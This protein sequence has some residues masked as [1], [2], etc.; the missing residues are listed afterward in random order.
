MFKRDQLILFAMAVLTLLVLGWAVWQDVQPEYLGYQRSFKRLVADKLGPEKAANVR[1]GV[2]QVWI[3]SANR[4]DRCMTCHLGVSWTGLDDV[5]E[6]FRSHPV[7]PLKNHPI[8]KFGCTFCH[9]GQGSATKRVDAHGWIKHWK[10]PLLDT[11][12]SED[13]QVKEP[14]AFLQMKCNTCHRYDRETP[15][16][17]YIN[18][19]KKLVNEKGCRACHTINERGGTIGPDLT[20]AGD[21]APE[22]YDYTR[23]TT[24]PSV[25][26]WQVAHMQDPKAYSPDT[27][28]PDFGLDSQASQAMAMLL[29]SWK[30]TELPAEFMHGAKIRDLPTP[31]E[32]ERE[33]V[34][35]EGEGKFFV[36]KTCFICHDVSSLGIVSATKIGPDLAIAEDDVPRRFGRTLDDF[37]HNPSGTMAVVLSKQIHLAPEEVDEAIK[38]LKVANAKYKQQKQAEKPADTGSTEG[39]PGVSGSRQSQPAH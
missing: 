20:S 3:P 25:F 6:P 33:R 10:D 37:L 27:V 26:S 32:A 7:E 14:W 1:F 23:L 21:K 38:L 28:M 15:G 5:D 24:Y 30:E 39:D 36:E 11:G 17:D 13:Y 2:Q 19:A 31:E 35:R 8:D 22:Q 34:M 18:M 12:V 29:L 16:A 4:V 9:G